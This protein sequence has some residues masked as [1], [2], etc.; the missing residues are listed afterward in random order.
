M[1]SLWVALQLFLSSVTVYPQSAQLSYSGSLSLKKGYNTFIWTDLPPSVA[2]SLP[3]LRIALP[4]TSRAYLVESRLDP[5]TPTWQEEPSD[6]KSARHAIDSLEKVLA[7]WQARLTLLKAQ[8]ATLLENKK[9]GGEEGPTSAPA[10]EAYLRLLAR[11]L[12][13]IQEAMYPLQKNLTQWTDTLKRWKEAYLARKA[14]YSQNRAA[15]HLRIWSPKEEVTSIRVEVQVPSAS[16]RLQYLIRVPNAAEGKAFIQ[17][18]AFVSNQTGLDWK[19]VQLTL[20]T[21]QPRLD[22]TLPPFEPWYIDQ[23]PIGR[24][25]K[26]MTLSPQ[27]SEAAEKPDEASEEDAET[28]APPTPLLQNTTL[29]RIYALGTQTLL[30]GAMTSQFLLKEDTL[31]GKL[32]FVVNAPAKEEAYLRMGLPLSTYELWEPGKATLDVEGQQVGEIHWP[33]PPTED[34]VWLDLGPTPRVT[35]KREEIRRTREKAL[36]SN[37]IRYQFS[38]RLRITHTYP[39]LITL[40][41]W[42]RIPISRYSD[43]KVELT[44]SGSALLDSETGRLS[45]QATLEPLQTWEKVFSFSIKAPSKLAIIGL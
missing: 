3:S 32:V 24:Y 11:E 13:P 29:S 36:A 7:S 18:R 6:L 28:T 40:S 17:R 45:W 30:T 39:Q 22:A 37:T 43:I 16:W 26:T 4:S 41:I 14:T 9:L 23:A 12:P 10:V 25:S 1:D 21:A 19:N 42:D 33:P 35:I 5:Y 31:T 34:T 38:Y 20:S 27:A 44:E 15:L 2:T 8:E